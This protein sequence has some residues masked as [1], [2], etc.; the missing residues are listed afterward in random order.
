MTPIEIYTLLRQTHEGNGWPWWNEPYDLNLF[1]IRNDNDIPDGWDDVLGIAYVDGQDRPQVERF[2]GTTDPGRHYLEAPMN[3]G[4]TLIVEPGYHRSLWQPGIHSG[5]YSALVQVG[6]VTYR[7][8]ADR[9]ATLDRDGVLMTTSGNAVN[10]HHGGGSVRVGRYSAG[11]QVVR[12]P[13]ALTRILALVELQKQ[14][15]HGNTISYALTDVRN[16]P[17]LRP[18]LG[19]GA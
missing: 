13:S 9:D 10:L 7:R 14:H 16:S 19:L 6:E 11:C 2:V 15:G 1:G 12:M 3:S 17:A 5:K 18:L 8:D 4:G